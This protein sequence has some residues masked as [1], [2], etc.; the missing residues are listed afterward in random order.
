MIRLTLNSHTKPEIHLF[1]KSIITLGRDPAQTDLSLPSL[2]LQPIHLKIVE[3]NSRYYLINITNDPFIS[4]NDLP[5]GRKQLNSGDVIHIHETQILFEKLQEALKT[6]KNHPHVSSEEPLAQILDK[7]IKNQ[8]QSTSHPNHITVGGNA[9]SNSLF[10][11]LP[12]ENDV[13]ALSDVEW[14]PSSIDQFLHP[15]S[16]ETYQKIIES[17]TTKKSTNEN[18]KKTVGS[19]KDDY[20][21]DL[22]DEN[23]TKIAPDDN[24]HLLQAWRWIL[25]F[26]FSIITIAGIIGTVIFFSISDKTEAQEVKAAQGVADIAMALTHAQIYQ[27]KPTNQNWSDVDF[28]KTNLQSI[29]PNTFSYALELDSHGQFNQIPYSLRIYT[30]T[31]F[32]HFL[33]IAQPAPSLL[34]WLIPKSI[35][36]VDSR[37]MELRTVKDIRS[38]NRLLAAPAPLDDINGKEIASLVKQGVLIR[39]SALAHDSKQMDFAPPKV[40]G[41][42]EAGSE[43]LIYNAPRYFNLGQPL[44]QKAIALSTTKGTSQ[45]VAAFKHHIEIFSGLQNLIIYAEDGKESAIQS[46]R[47]F[48]T[49]A[50]AE[51]ILFGY[52][53]FNSEGNLNH[54]SLLRDT[55]EKFSNL[56]TNEAIAFNS[57]PF[58]TL[59]TNEDLKL[60]LSKT[61]LPSIDDSDTDDIDTN[62]PIYA[63]LMSLSKAREK[64]LQPIAVKIQTM[65]DREIQ[66]PEINFQTHFQELSHQF[67]MID[68]KHKS[69]LKNSMIALYE[70]YQE[71]PVDQFLQF[72]KKA[73]CEKLICQ[74]GGSVSLADESCLQNL[75]TNLTQIKNSK[76]LVELDNFI[77][78]AMAWLTF[79]YISNPKELMEYQNRLRNQVLQQLEKLLLSNQNH[80]NNQGLSAEEKESL[81]NILGIER[82]I[83]PEE[84]E[85]F[86]E[87][88]ERFSSDQNVVDEKNASGDNVEQVDKSKPSQND[89]EPVDN[90]EKNHDIKVTRIY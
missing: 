71:M 59:I 81:K 31:N 53:E 21:K 83:K 85:F 48:Q 82:L 24:H 88:F 39:L 35:I 17:V 87:E 62:H 42:A 37:S 25:L 44:I 29:L 6:E 58:D 72:V 3:E 43:N 52:L 38:L 55:E 69:E 5:F 10:I 1:N 67:L 76:S 9:K 90:K 65:L 73:G 20:L 56:E 61:L 32:S 54:V 49:F 45:D 16:E 7:K 27:H 36:V 57:N 4:I 66:F 78:I 77:D 15:E 30:N 84:Q 75:E 79:D 63:K 23:Q 13:E 70:Q 19:L 41:W 14:N 86:L 26:I 51:N 60:N 46:K 11:D 74:T 47:G 40:L 33:L 89:A 22:D 12:F 18:V 34:Q 8:E 68:S 2:P 50:P 64:E 80:L 28:L